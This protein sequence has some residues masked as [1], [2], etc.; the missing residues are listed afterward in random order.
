LRLARFGGQFGDLADEVAAVAPQEEATLRR[1][2][3]DEAQAALA[4]LSQAGAQIVFEAPKPIFRAPTFRCSDWFNA[5]TPV[6][7]G[8]LTEDAQFLRDYRSR[9]SQR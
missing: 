5:H 2:A 8:G 6:C 7:S 1:Q 3:I 4:E 9:W